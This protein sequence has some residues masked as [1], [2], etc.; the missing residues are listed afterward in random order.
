[1]AIFPHSA[2]LLVVAYDLIKCHKKILPFILNQNVKNK[3]TTKEWSSSKRDNKSHF[4]LIFT[5]NMKTKK[6]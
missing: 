2:N 5:K 4:P 1:M 6:S 3:T